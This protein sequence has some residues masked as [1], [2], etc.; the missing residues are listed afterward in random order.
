MLKAS[1]TA[2]D[3][4]LVLREPQLKQAQFAVAAAKA[5]LAEVQLDLDRTSIRS[6]FNAVVKRETIG[7]GTLVRSGTSLGLLV[8][9]DAYWVMLSVPVDELQFISVPGFNAPAGK[10][11]SVRIECEA[12]WG[13][14]KFRTGTVTR[15]MSDLEPQGRMARIVVTVDDPRSRKPENADKPHLL[16]GS[17][18]RA[19]ITGKTL[20]N[21]MLLPRSV[22]HENNIVWVARIAKPAGAVLGMQTISPLFKT[23]ETIWIPA[24]SIRTG[25]R[26][27]KTDLSTPVAGMKLR[28]QGDP[29]ATPKAKVKPATPAGSVK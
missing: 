20:T 11:S 27:I 29:V 18:V 25:D 23:R 8:N 9:T 5:R 21:V 7:V 10:G 13:K 12:G 14:G 22:V 2:E 24:D 1:V 19:S 4:E 17:Y 28:V 6:P 3:R 26:I 16:L 15:L